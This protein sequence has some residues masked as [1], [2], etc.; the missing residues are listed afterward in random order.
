MLTMVYRSTYFI[1]VAFI[2]ILVTGC[3]K[4]SPSQKVVADTATPTIPAGPLVRDVTLPGRQFQCPV[5]LPNGATPPLEA[6]SPNRLGNGVLW[7]TLW[8]NG[9]V[10]FEPGGPGEMGE[11]LSLSMK[12]PWWRGIA[13][14]L[15]IN[16]ARLD[17]PGTL[18]ASI[19]GG[20]GA[21]GFQATALIF[22]GP[23]CWEVVA[24][25]GD[26]GLT[27]ITAIEL[28]PAA[29]SRQPFALPIRVCLEDG[30]WQRPG[31]EQQA[32]HINADNRYAPFEPLHREQ[33]QAHFW[34]G[35]ASAD[36][37]GAIVE[38]SG[39]WTM[40]AETKFSALTVGCPDQPN[41]LNPDLLDIWLLGYRAD[42]ASF[43]DNKVVIRV[44]PRNPG[45]QVIQIRLPPDISVSNILLS[46]VD[47]NGRAVEEVP[48]TALR[49][50][51]P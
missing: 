26:E 29:A 39:L 22:S 42:G 17:A 23:G 31:L 30:S 24:H 10:I 38:F 48:P 16:G 25:V 43:S 20:Y 45:F 3:A 33:F 21:V 4:D 49:S 28:K 2:L 14:S 13:G 1:G 6:P 8:P 37:I 40:G 19:P 11:D 44:S 32:E 34:R 50:Q 9:T 36:L 46:F 41:V 27:F 35:I 51:A 7:T 12:W 5:T 18:R 47:A 15:E